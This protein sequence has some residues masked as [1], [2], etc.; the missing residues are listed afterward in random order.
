M[1]INVV[2]IKVAYII[3]LSPNKPM[4]I[5]VASA[6]ARILTILFPNNNIPITLSLEFI[7]SLAL[8]YFLFLL[9]PH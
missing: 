1:N 2:I 5:L 3:P 7:N 6:E 9:S 4:R 8:I